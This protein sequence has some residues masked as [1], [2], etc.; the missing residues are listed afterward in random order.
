MTD[1][2]TIE[3]P[4]QAPQPAEQAAEAAPPAAKGRKPNRKGIGGTFSHSPNCK[5]NPC[6]ARRQR[7]EAEGIVKEE[8]I[9]APPGRKPC[10][11]KPLRARV[12]QF[13]HY[14]ATKPNATKQQIAE[15]MGLTSR[16][17]H[18]ILK[19]ARENDLL[20]LDDPLERIEL[21]IIPKVVDNLAYYLNQKDKTVTI[22]TAKGTL[23]K[24]FAAEK[25]IQDQPS[26]VLA[27]KIEMPDS[28][29][30]PVVTAGRIVGVPKQL[31]SSLSEPSDDPLS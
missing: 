19:Q 16:Q 22:E 28:S 31:I 25:G 11:P 21:E 9:V 26:T 10:V 1:E 20:V 8:P 5:C 2:T 23:F 30:P 18:T 4:E 7:L 13:L 12:A 14:S 3:Q 29:S 6:R 17:L 15:M 24:Q 27:L